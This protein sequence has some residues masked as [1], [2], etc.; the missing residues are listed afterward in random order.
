MFDFL[1]FILFYSVLLGLK[2]HVPCCLFLVQMHKE[3]TKLRLVWVRLKISPVVTT[4]ITLIPSL[5]GAAVQADKALHSLCNTAHPCK[6]AKK[7]A[8]IGETCS[9]FFSEGAE[10]TADFHPQVVKL[11]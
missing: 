1:L 7:V 3:E 8:C 10:M 4:S 9:Y 6:E 5:G 2:P 11:P